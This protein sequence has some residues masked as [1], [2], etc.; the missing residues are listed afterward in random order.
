MVLQPSDHALCLQVWSR[1]MSVP[2]L[3]GLSM[4]PISGSITRAGVS[5]EV[6]GRIIFSH[7]QWESVLQDRRGAFISSDFAFFQLFQSSSPLMQCHL[8]CYT[9]TPWTFWKCGGFHPLPPPPALPPITLIPQPFMWPFPVKMVPL[10]GKGQPLLFFFFSFVLVSFFFF[11]SFALL[12]VFCC[13]SYIQAVV[14]LWLRAQWGDA[15]VSKVRKHSLE[16]EGWR[17][18]GVRQSVET[19][20]WRQAEALPPSTCAL[21]CILYTCLNWLFWVLLTNQ[22]TEP[23]VTDKKLWNFLK[24]QMSKVNG[25]GTHLAACAQLILGLRPTTW[26]IFLTPPV[27]G[28]AP[29]FI[30]FSL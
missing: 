19:S 25:L 17:Q 23:K 27:T 11:F 22:S 26:R 4:I 18:A 5:V 15:W 2:S 28:P 21:K 29:Q 13:V 6:R 20:R 24:S 9:H 7:K 10:T 3:E 8:E 12:T 14:L 16:W 1:V 30:Y